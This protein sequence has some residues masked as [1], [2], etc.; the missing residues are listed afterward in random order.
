MFYLFLFYCSPAPMVKKLRYYA[1]FIVVCL[2]LNNRKV[3]LLLDRLT[4]YRLVILINY[5]F[6]LNIKMVTTL[7]NELNQ[8]VELYL[9][10]FNP[11]DTQEWQFVLQE[12]RQF[13]NADNIITIE[14]KDLPSR[15]LNSGPEQLSSRIK[16]QEVL[17]V[18]NCSNQVKFSELTLD[19]FRMMQAVEW[20]PSTP[21][22]SSEGRKKGKRNPHKYLLYRPTMSQVLVF[23]ANSFKELSDNNVMLLY[24]SADGVSE[25]T[26]GNPEEPNIAESQNLCTKGGIALNS[27]RP[28]EKQ[29]HSGVTP[30]C[31]YPEDLLTYTRK[32]LFMI[33]D[34]E[35]SSAFDVCIIIIFIIYI[36]IIILFCICLL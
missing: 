25:P 13:L 3:L 10:T 21:D 15:R 31:L 28:L 12:I 6:L 11:S 26:V 32:H 33:I 17:L 9:K 20:E 8:E 35:N 22:L 16:L 36:F 27:R 1:R 19:M 34:S 4:Y 5:F 2:L 7:V 23:L 29:E 14:N 18:G 24:I 30:G